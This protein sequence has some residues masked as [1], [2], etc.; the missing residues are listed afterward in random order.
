[1]ND[2]TVLI[3][4]DDETL[5]RA[6]ALKLRAAG[7]EVLVGMDGLQAVMQAQR[8][9][10]DLILLDV[11]M[12]AGDGIYVMDK[13]HHSISTMRIP[14]IVMS[15]MEDEDLRDKV[16]S[17]GAIGFVRKPFDAD[18]LIKAVD[19]AFESGAGV[20]QSADRPTRID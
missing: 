17:L 13:L 18:A 16:S 11:R 9:D 19:L 10:P 5:V 1:M 14:V 12:P 7:Y 2:K 3:V 4:D 20:R 6:L 15:A 8:K